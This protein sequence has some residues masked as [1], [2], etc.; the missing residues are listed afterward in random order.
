M[1]RAP[2]VAR[3]EQA[4]QPALLVADGK[5]GLPGVG[6]DVGQ[7]KP[8]VTPSSR[9]DRTSPGQVVARLEVLQDVR[10]E[11]VGVGGE[12]K[13]FSTWFSYRKRSG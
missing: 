1:E 11:I 6:D 4:R 9:I 10:D 13:R 8:R 2:G 12:G 7:G 3:V 5:A